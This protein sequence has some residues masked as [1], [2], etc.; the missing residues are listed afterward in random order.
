[1]RGKWQTTPAY[2]S[3]FKKTHSFKDKVSDLEEVCVFHPPRREV[4]SQLFSKR[5][6]EAGLLMGLFLHTAVLS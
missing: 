4:S 3:V 1:M 6:R 5:Y 2:L